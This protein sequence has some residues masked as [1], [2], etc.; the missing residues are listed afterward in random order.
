MSRYDNG[1]KYIIDRNLDINKFSQEH[2]IEIGYGISNKYNVDYYIDCNY[3]LNL[4]TIIY[5]CL[6][7][8]YY[9][10]NGTE[11]ATKVSANQKIRKIKLLKKYIKNNYSY[12]L[13]KKI[14]KII[15]EDKENIEDKINLAIIEE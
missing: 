4:I 9:F 14:Y 8:N 13:C 3:S 6:Y 15:S 10:V 2:I 12:N 7:T 11:P 1:S 5:K